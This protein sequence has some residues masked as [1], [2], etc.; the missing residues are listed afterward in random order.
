VDKEL[1]SHMQIFKELPPKALEALAQTVEEVRYGAG[2]VVFKEGET[3]DCLF[4]VVS[5]DIIIRKFIDRSKGTHKIISYLGSGDCFGE[6]ALLDKGSRSATAQAKDTC[7]LLR[8]KRDHLFDLLS[9]NPAAAITPC[10][11]LLGILSSRLRQTT[12]EL[13]TVY[14]VGRIIGQS[15]DR[16]LLAKRILDRILESLQDEEGGTLHLWNLYNEEYELAAQGGKLP[17]Q[18]ARGFEKKHE[19]IQWMI[20]R[21]AV[22]L[23]HQWKKDVCFDSA[24]R[25]DLGDIKSLLAVPLFSE[26]ELIGF[27]TLVHT[28][29]E[30]AFGSSH[31][32]LVHAVAQLSV[33]AFE[34]AAAR[35]EEASRQKLMQAR[36]QYR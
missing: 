11:A 33:P 9:K 23:S 1:L 25:K 22:I 20:K 24:T 35:E 10:L 34:N 13:V 3:G 8:L 18:L 7:V 36:G 2:E 30:A 5:G 29:R 16:F 6:M 32:Q 12:R 21:Q 19:M 14:E 4:L 27:I 28:G 26:K 17:P 15:S 31:L